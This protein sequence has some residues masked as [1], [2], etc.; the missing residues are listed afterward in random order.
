MSLDLK[1][2]DHILHYL[3]E[4]LLG[5]GGEA[6]VY[7]ARDTRLK[8]KL[9]LKTVNL[10]TQSHH[11]GADHGLEEARLIAQLNHPNILQ[12][13]HAER[14]EKTYLI[15]MEYMTNGSLDCLIDEQG[16]RS[17]GEALHQVVAI[18]DALRHAHA[19]G[20]IHRDIKPHNL[21]ISSRGTIKLADFGLAFQYGNFRTAPL[22]SFLGSP[23]FIAPEIWKGQR[24]SGRSDIYSLGG[25][26]FYA[27][28]GSPP[29]DHP[30]IDGLREAHLNTVPRLPL[31]LPRSISKL[32]LACLSKDPHR[33]PDAAMLYDECVRLLSEKFSSPER[34][35]KHFVLPAMKK[36]ELSVSRSSLTAKAEDFLSRL[37]RFNTARL[38]FIELLR[39]AKPLFVHSSDRLILTHLIR[40]TLSTHAGDKIPWIIFRSDEPL[41]QE[42]VDDRNIFSAFD[43]T[44]APQP[45]IL[46]LEGPRLFDRDPLPLIE[47]IK[48]ASRRGVILVVL[49]ESP[50]DAP[51]L[52]ALLS[53]SDGVEVPIDSLTPFELFWYARVC[54]KAATRGRILWS[55]KA[56]TLAIYLAHERHFSYDKLLFNSLMISKGIGRRVITTWSIIGAASHQEMIMGCSD[57]LEAWQ[58]PPKLWPTEDWRSQLAQLSP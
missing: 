2:G 46:V 58:S 23:R 30:S 56:L 38:H 45:R 1:A 53:V 36:P 28:T 10:N 24:A 43:Q 13:Y 15:A 41:S 18:A 34:E 6:T 44:D 11:Q 9:A 7:L 40:V 50:A 57:V 25:C 48:E 35:I 52:A 39:G 49:S 33:R 55:R 4:G 16:P 42:H 26:L 27:L 37:Q 31:I 5:V 14:I 17:C 21:L 51:S 54:T 3:I 29:F 47:I 8:R 32:I 22:N 12:V 20:V 19:L